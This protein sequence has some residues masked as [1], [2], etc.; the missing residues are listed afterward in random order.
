M[1]F[2]VLVSQCDNRVPGV[3]VDVAARFLTNRTAAHVR[4]GGNTVSTD[5]R[6]EGKSFRGG[7]D[8]VVAR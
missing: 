3:G 1:F 7:A 8:E 5:V 6:G 2:F 4:I